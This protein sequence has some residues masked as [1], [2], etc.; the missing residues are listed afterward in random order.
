MLLLLLNGRGHHSQ[1]RVPVALEVVD[2][3]SMFSPHSGRLRYLL[4][5]IR[6]QNC[7]AKIEEGNSAGC[8][9]RGLDKKE[10]S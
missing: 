6:R 8:R 4:E 1:S 10:P 2:V 7:V 9:I 3:V 5:K